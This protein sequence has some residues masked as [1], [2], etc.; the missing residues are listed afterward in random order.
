MLTIN[1]VERTKFGSSLFGYS[2]AEVDEFVD[3][4]L[5][6]LQSHVEELENLKKRVAEADAAI[7]LHRANEDTLKSSIVLAQKSHDEIVAAA[8]H[9]AENIIKEAQ[10]KSV[11]VSADYAQLRA[12]RERFEFEFHVLL[13]AFLDRLEAQRPELQ[14]AAD[15]VG[16]AGPAS[17]ERSDAA[18]PGNPRTTQT[19]DEVVFPDEEAR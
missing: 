17:S 7:E 3:E 10:L 8:H 13:R 12:D 4:V 2:R 14:R 18:A 15:T 6:T 1:D 19:K 5:A 9:E 16:S 11:Q